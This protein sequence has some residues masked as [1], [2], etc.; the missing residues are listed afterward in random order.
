M[1]RSQNL[2]ATSHVHFDT[3]HTFSDM[4]SGMECNWLLITRAEFTPREG[5]PMA[6]LGVPWI[7]HPEGQST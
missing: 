2:D 3:H 7:R 1:Y 4:T 6:L 5:G